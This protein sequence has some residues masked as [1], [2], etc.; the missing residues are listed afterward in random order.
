MSIKL[1]FP[2]TVLLVWWCR[3]VIVW[4]LRIP[5]SFSVF[6]EPSAPPLTLPLTAIHSFL[7][8]LLTALLLIDSHFSTD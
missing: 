1:K 7:L 5:S 3:T 8:L 2:T 4:R 6:I